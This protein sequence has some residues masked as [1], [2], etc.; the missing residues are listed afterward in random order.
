MLGQFIMEEAEAVLQP[1]VL[2][3]RQLV[4]FVTQVEVEME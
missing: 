3:V 2:L 1:L 4:Q